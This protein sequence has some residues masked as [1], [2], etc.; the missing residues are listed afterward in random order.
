MTNTTK[1]SESTTQQAN[2]IYSD[3]GG[4]EGMAELVELY[5]DEMPERIETLDRCGKR[6][7]IKELARLAHQLKGAAG[8]YGFMQISEIAE[9]LDRAIKIC[10][11]P[12]DLQRVEDLLARTIDACRRAKAGTP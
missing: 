11:G 10:S 12:S 6:Q 8:S 3:F 7:D 1:L 4:E 5:V 2:P 9:Q